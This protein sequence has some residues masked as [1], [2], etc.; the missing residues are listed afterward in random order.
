M[1]TAISELSQLNSA[2][3]TDLFIISHLSGESYVT[4]SLSAGNFATKDY[5]S[6]QISA[7]VGNINSIL[8][9][10]NVGNA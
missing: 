3:D 5:L 4:R 8:E 9:A 10:I 6:A 1:A 2:T 7:T